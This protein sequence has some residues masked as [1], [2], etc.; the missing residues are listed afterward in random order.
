MFL[1]TLHLQKFQINRLSVFGAKRF[2]S[3]NYKEYLKESLNLQTEEDCYNITKNKFNHLEK[4]QEILKETNSNSYEQA[5]CKILNDYSLIP[6]KFPAAQEKE[7]W[8]KGSNQRIF[9]LYIQKINNI[10]YY[11]VTKWDKITNEYIISMGG[12]YFLELYDFKL[13]KALYALFPEKQDDFLYHWQKIF[14]TKDDEKFDFFIKIIREKLNIKKSI[15]WVK[16]PR[17]T[18]DDICKPLQIHHGGLLGVLNRS[19]PRINWT[20][21]YSLFQNQG[22]EN[23]ESFDLVNLKFSKK[24]SKFDNVIHSKKYQIKLRTFVD[25]LRVKYSLTTESSWEK[26]SDSQIKSIEGGEELLQQYG[27]LVNILLT[28][29]PNFF[30]DFRENDF[31]KKMWSNPLFYRFLF[32]QICE[33]KNLDIKQLTETK[34]SWLVRSHPL[35]N[36]LLALG[37]KNLLPD[38]FPEISNWSSSLVHH[39]KEI[40]IKK[41]SNIYQSY[42]KSKQFGAQLIRKY[43]R[44]WNFN[45]NP[46]GCWMISYPISTS[47]SFIWDGN[48][49]LGTI[50]ASGNTSKDI[51]VPDEI[52]EVLPKKYLHI[53]VK[54]NKNAK[55]FTNN[56]L[57]NNPAMKLLIL[58]SIIP[59]SFEK[60]LESIHKLADSSFIEKPNYIKC[61]DMK[62]FVNFVSN[63]PH[64]S[65][66]LLVPPNSNSYL[67]DSFS[68]EIYKYDVDSAILKDT[69]PKGKLLYCEK[70]GNLIDVKYF[71][72]QILNVRAEPNFEAYFVNT[73]DKS[74]ILLYLLASKD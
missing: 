27:S 46:I 53:I 64:K 2:V 67:G 29:Y 50:K 40:P 17:K 12:K 16:I 65:K 43:F 66:I 21:L 69:N 32:L 54:Y 42:K 48:K 6:W 41:L 45:I 52:K 22:N 3:Q 37:G 13:Y 25:R 59:I 33:R 7:F 61:K 10:P 5:L 14:D 39:Y 1:R 9:L 11:N 60:R 31:T 63:T 28:A 20:D 19:D 74:N 26:L 38:L 70:D 73:S 51:D 36:H 34:N 72:D 30:N 24:A 47:H 62:D 57:I 18:I 35:G 55:I 58:D 4:A 49:L 15:D 56:T 44:H 23:G 8:T 68:Y 71:N